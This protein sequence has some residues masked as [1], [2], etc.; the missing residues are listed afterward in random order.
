M[1]LALPPSVSLHRAVGT[2]NSEALQLGESSGIDGQV[3][4]YEPQI[5]AIIEHFAEGAAEK[6]GLKAREEAKGARTFWDRHVGP[7]KAQQER[8][9]A[10]AASAADKTFSVGSGIAQ[11]LVKAALPTVLK[12]REQHLTSAFLSDA[13]YAAAQIQG[14]ALPYSVSAYVH[15]HALLPFGI[16]SKLADR[17]RA[18]SK[19][20]EFRRPGKVTPELRKY[21]GRVAVVSRAKALAS[22]TNTSF[23]LLFDQALDRDLRE[24][25]KG[26]AGFVEA[27]IQD[28]EDDWFDSFVADSAD[29]AAVALL[30]EQTL[31]TV[32]GNLSIDQD[33]KRAI[34]ERVRG[35]ADPDRGRRD[36]ILSQ[37]ARGAAVAGRVA[38]GRQASG[39]EVRTRCY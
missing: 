39:W 17:G 4:A 34:V 9:D 35:Y 15:S 11:F 29:E 32:C 6:A 1:P 22:T 20:S 36:R 26:M 23:E 16:A 10:A 7:S 18:P 37:S 21:V 8:E 33:T 3:V 38:L 13:I 31:W 19:A 28:L 24:T 27:D 30:A 2:A 12:A 5:N 25:L 14:A